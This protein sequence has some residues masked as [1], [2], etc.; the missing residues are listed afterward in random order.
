MALTG[1]QQRAYG[2][3]REAPGAKIEAGT[4]GVKRTTVEALERVGLV[5]VTRTVREREMKQRGSTPAHLK[6]VI[7]WTAQLRPI[8]PNSLQIEE[9]DLIAESPQTS[10]LPSQ[11]DQ[12]AAYVALALAHVVLPG[13]DSG[14]PDYSPTA[15]YPVYLALGDHELLDLYLTVRQ[16]TGERPQR[17]NPRTALGDVTDVWEITQGTGPGGPVIELG[18]VQESTQN[19]AAIAAISLLNRRDGFNLRRMGSRELG[20]WRKDFRAGG[21]VLRLAATG[22]GREQVTVVKTR[23]VL[24]TRPT[25]HEA[26]RDARAAYESL[27]AALPTG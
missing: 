7:H 21:T 27:S 13:T 16:L 18:R 6:T 23:A 17:P 26:E 12:V 3:M 14:S 25:V 15:Q 1:A 2:I 24:V 11:H 5:T 22:D 20:G 4:K 9:L 19:A 10:M 8:M